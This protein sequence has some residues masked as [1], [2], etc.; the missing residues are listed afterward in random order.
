MYGGIDE[1]WMYIP[2]FKKAQEYIDHRW[3]FFKENGYIETPMFNRKIKKCHIEDPS[4]N[5]LFNY[6]LQAYETE[7]AVN[8]LQSLLEYAKSKKTK[9]ILYTYDSI[10]FDAHKE[11]KISTLQDIKKIMEGDKFPV[12]VYVGK[13]YGDMKQIS[14]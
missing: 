13:N 12:K 14:L 2:Y 9:P 3:K 11:D 5:K 6:I 4:P 1:K 8:T 10:L 7:M